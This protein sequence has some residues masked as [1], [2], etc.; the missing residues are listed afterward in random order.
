MPTDPNERFDALLEAMATKPPHEQ[1][2]DQGPD[3]DAD[4]NDEDQD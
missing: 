4:L 2:S 1:S 3:E